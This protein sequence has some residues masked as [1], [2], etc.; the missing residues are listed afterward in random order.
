MNAS[1]VGRSNTT[2][3]LSSFSM[4]LMPA[5]SSIACDDEHAQ[6]SHRRGSKNGA[7]L[8]P[9]DRDDTGCFVRHCGPR[10]PAFAFAETFKVPSTAARL[11]PNDMKHAATHLQQVCVAQ[12][13]LD[14]LAHALVALARQRVPHVDGSVPITGALQSR[15]AHPRQTL[16][17]SVQ[18]LALLIRTG[19]RRSHSAYAFKI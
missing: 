1:S 14:V 11:R 10:Y 7:I 15:A 18:V 9:Y 12:A 2:V 17:K 6:L 16:C 8:T 3:L 5:P 19:R 13:F 4:H